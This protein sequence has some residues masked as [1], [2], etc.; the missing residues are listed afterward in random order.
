MHKFRHWPCKIL[1][2][3]GDG[4]QFCCVLVIESCVGRE[5]QRTWRNVHNVSDL[6]QALVGILHAVAVS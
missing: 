2:L 5:T 3:M 4:E 6:V 1:D